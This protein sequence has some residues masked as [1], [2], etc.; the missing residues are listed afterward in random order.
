MRLGGILPLVAIIEPEQEAEYE[1]EAQR[2]SKSG[3]LGLPG[4]RG[5]GSIP[6]ERLQ[7]RSR[8]KGSGS[9]VHNMRNPRRRVRVDRNDPTA[10]VRTVSKNTP[11]CWFL[12]GP[13][14]RPVS[15]QR[16]ELLSAGSG[17]YRSPKETIDRFHP[18]RF[19]GEE[20]ESLRVP[21][22]F[23]CS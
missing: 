15:P 6:S 16:V 21:G 4:Q 1:E 5:E 22:N 2:R 12:R 3:F 11:R 13:T 19:E 7:F 23:H 9:L 14:Y 20:R 10:G 8:L 17:A 18:S